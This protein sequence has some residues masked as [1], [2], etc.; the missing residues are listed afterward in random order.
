MRFIDPL[1]LAPEPPRLAEGEKVYEN[2][3]GHGGS[4]YKS[5]DGNWYHTRTEND[6][7]TTSYSYNSDDGWEVYE[8]DEF[9]TNIDGLGQFAEETSQV[10]VNACLLYTSPSPRD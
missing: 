1:G 5:E 8:S 9:P 7:T 6:G 3:Y 2:L 10:A 4:T